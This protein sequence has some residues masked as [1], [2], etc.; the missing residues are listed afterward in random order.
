M[1]EELKTET[2]SLEHR[3]RKPRKTA[4]SSCNRKLGLNEHVRE[5][6]LVIQPQVTDVDETIVYDKC[7]ISYIMSNATKES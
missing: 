6:L 7:I 5:G 3:K 1:I 4:T 2:I